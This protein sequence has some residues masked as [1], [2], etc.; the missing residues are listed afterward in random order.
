MLYVT[1]FIYFRMRAILSCSVW[2]LSVNLIPK[3]RGRTG[4]FKPISNVSA[5]LPLVSTS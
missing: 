2:N 4:L 5:F 3:E 1:G